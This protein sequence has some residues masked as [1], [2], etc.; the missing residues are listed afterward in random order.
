MNASKPK[1]RYQVR[2]EISWEHTLSVLPSQLAGDDEESPDCVVVT[3]APN[4]TPDAHAS[5]AP[6]DAGL[7]A[8]APHILTIPYATR[9]RKSYK[10]CK[11]QGSHSPLLPFSP[12]V[13]M[14]FGGTKF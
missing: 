11:C 5:M 10:V 8:N 7:R 2:K 3:N 12:L 14:A 1:E 9:T 4:P 13:R 6:H